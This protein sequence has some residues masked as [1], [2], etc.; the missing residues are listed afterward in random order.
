MYKL[1]IV[2]DEKEIREGLKTVL[3]WA[4]LG[5]EVVLTADDGDTALTIVK[6]NQVDIIITD[7][8]MNRMSGLEFI[9]NMHEDKIFT[10]KSIVISGYDDFESVKEALK[11]GLMDYILKPIN[12]DE[13]I[14]IVKKAID[15][16]QTENFDKQNQLF[17]ENQLNSAIPQLQEQFLRGFLDKETIIESDCWI[18][19]RLMC[20]QMEWLKDNT[21]ALL[22]LE[23]DDLK[24]IE[25]TKK[26]RREKELV[27]FAIENVINQTMQEEGLQPFALFADKKDRW[28]LLVQFDDK[29]NLDILESLAKL[30][31]ERLNKYV[32]VNVTIS[33]SPMIDG[34]SKLYSSYRKAIEILERKVIIGGNRL[35]GSYYMEEDNTPSQVCLE[36]MA[37]VIDLIKYGTEIEIQESFHSFS[38]M[39]KNWSFT[40][41]KDIQQHTFEWLMELFKKA[42]AA[43]WKERWREQNLIAVWE[44]IEQFDTLD[45]L[46][47]LTMSYVINI[48]NS[49]KQNQHPHNQIIKEAEAYISKH[50][51]D[52][53]TLQ[54][55]ADHVHI[56]PVWLSKL[57]KKEKKT[58][59]LEY[60]TAVRIAQAKVLLNDLQYRIYQ[61]ALEVGYKDSV[62]FTKIFKKVVGY[63]PKE[64]R[65]MRG[66]HNE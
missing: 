43:G 26:Y 15:L 11:L 33:I 30:I 5:V 28:V 39:V 4:E 46:Q 7:I 62:H 58:L 20:V 51:A 55:V 37:E 44:Q 24:A 34:L 13:L 6:E 53:L 61:V 21:F 49:F 50:F 63:T 36:N 64:Y 57:F 32:K 54:L 45:S 66:I 8:K 17:R 19:D 22:V 16:I 2:D 31:I 9:K 18:K 40:H 48:A 42:E 3:P 27:L 52:N 38:T 1:L 23:V 35:L 14:Q 59:F 65:N 25:E 41:I 12:I 47:N 10:G 60:L 29:N 56:T